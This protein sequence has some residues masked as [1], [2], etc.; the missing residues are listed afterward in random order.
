[1]MAFGDSTERRDTEPARRAGRVPLTKRER[2]ILGPS[3][4][5]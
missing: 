4:R 1:M 2:E 5:A 3:P